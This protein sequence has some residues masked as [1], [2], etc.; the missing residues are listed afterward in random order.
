MAITT[1]QEH[2]IRAVLINDEASTDE[3]LVSH[4][5]SEGAGRI[6]EQEARVWV[7]RRS[8]FLRGALGSVV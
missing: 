1:E 5:I 7:A 4:F 2:W 6:T 8:G 3:E